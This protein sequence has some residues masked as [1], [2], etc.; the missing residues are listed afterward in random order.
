MKCSRDTVFLA[1]V[2]EDTFKEKDLVING[3]W[4]M[5]SPAQEDL[6]FLSKMGLRFDSEVTLFTQMD[7]NAIVLEEVY[8]I[9]ED[10]PMEKNQ[11]GLWT[12]Y[13]GLTMTETY[14]WERRSDLQ[15]LAVSV[16]ALHVCFE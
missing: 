12:R 4:L 15:G 7:E 9:N 2:S 8:Q 11:V 3:R 6:E 16:P 10:L 14:I 13:Q 5:K 1:D